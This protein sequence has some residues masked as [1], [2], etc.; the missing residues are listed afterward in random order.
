MLYDAEGNYC[1]RSSNSYCC[2]RSYWRCWLS[3][4][5]AGIVVDPLLQVW[6]AREGHP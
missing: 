6:I 1:R 4:L 5:S 3:L 2:L